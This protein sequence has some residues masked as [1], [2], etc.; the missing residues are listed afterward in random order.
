MVTLYVQVGVDDVSTKI[1]T[2]EFW[3]K[4][5]EGVGRFLVKIKNASGEYL[6][7][8]SADDDF[9]LKVNNADI[10]KGYLDISRPMSVDDED[11]YRQIIAVVG[12]DYAQDLAN[13]LNANR[14]YN[15]KADDIIDDMLANS[16]PSACEVTFTSP[17]TAPTLDYSKG[18]DKHLSV[19]LR[20]I[21]EQVDY[22]CFVK[23]DKALQLFPIGTVSSGITLKSIADDATS[24]IIGRIER[25]EF[26]ALELWNYV[27]V[28]G[29]KVED[30]W[31]EGNASDYGTADAG[32]VITNEYSDVKKGVGAIKS[33]K[34]AATYCSLKLT[35]PLYNFTVLNLAK[36]GSMELAFWMK[37][38][39]SGLSG[40]MISPFVR[41]KDGD[42]RQIDW[43]FGYETESNAWMKYVVP[44]GLSATEYPNSIGVVGEKEKWI[45]A[46]GTGFN[47]ADVEEIQFHSLL[48]TVDYML[49]DGVALPVKM[50]A[51]SQDGGS[52]G[53]YKGRAKPFDRPDIPS[54]VELQA[55]ADSEK[56]KLKD[57]VAGLK[58][59][60]KGEDAITGEPATFK[61]WPGYTVVVNAPDDSINSETWRIL[62]LHGMIQENV[63]HGF[64][65]VIEADLV[66]QNAKVDTLRLSAINNPQAALLRDLAMQIRALQ[67]HEE[68]ALD[69]FPGLPSALTSKHVWE[70]RGTAFPSNP[71]DLQRFYRTDL[72]VWFRYSASAASWIPSM[73]TN[74]GTF[75][76]YAKDLVDATDAAFIEYTKLLA[77]GEMKSY[78]AAKRTFT[79]EA[80]TDLKYKK[81]KIM[82]ELR[83]AAT[84][85]PTAYGRVMYRFGGAG[86]WTQLGS[87]TNTTSTSWVARTV[88]GELTVGIDFDSQVE[89][90]VELGGQNDDPLATSWVQIRKIKVEYVE[91]QARGSDIG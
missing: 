43:D 23:P 64:D 2:I 80:V 52:Q 53:S 79:Y 13:K 7:S 71:A 73:G 18:V 85:N 30:G 38:Y 8:W 40:L 87:E 36:F 42:G 75:A 58:V 39:G 77:K 89:L 46:S 37:Q 31:S 17:A 63:Q 74:Y 15:Q 24:N 10:M 68:D 12:R 54:Q 5:T 66:P 59:F 57:P 49:L 86:G 48:S 26:D 62:Q 69:Y 44:V 61:T 19:C 56:N 41:L 9:W 50:V 22:D 90:A 21:A 32:N 16:V 47:W 20:D 1:K 72:L 67:K 35:F 45:Q 91:E 14:Y 6:G 4:A 76:G 29:K 83:C 3:M 55:F 27:I 70:N 60:F 65:F 81:A 11:I 28:R 82:F 33:A 88:S 34:G 25:T 84:G 78:D 51:I